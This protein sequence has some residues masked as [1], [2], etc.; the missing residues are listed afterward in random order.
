[1]RTVLLDLDGTLVDSADLITTHLAAALAHHERPVPDVS[2]LR[3]FI[4]PPLEQSLPEFGLTREQAAAVIATFRRAYNPVA[5]TSRLF[6]H[7]REL[8]ARLRAAGFRL[9][10]ATS[11]REVLAREIVSRNGLT[12]ELVGGADQRG[13]RI[14]KAA[15]VG[16]VLERLG[17]DPAHDPVVMVGD[18]VH[19]VEGAAVHGVPT[20]AVAWGYAEPGELIGAVTVVAGVDELLAALHTDPVWS[21]AA[22]A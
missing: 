8:V 6:P 3:R 4:G 12:V 22:A 9:A 18:R 14:G 7:T 5:A 21:C 13:V 11:K 20:V 10:V 2:T 15:V 1:M 19:D 17:I 16:S